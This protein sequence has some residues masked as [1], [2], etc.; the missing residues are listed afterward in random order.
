MMSAPQSRTVASHG[1]CAN[2]GQLGNRSQYWWHNDKIWI[3]YKGLFCGKTCLLEFHRGSMKSKH[4]ISPTAARGI[5]YNIALNAL[6]AAYHGEGDKTTKKAIAKLHN[7]LLD[8]SG[9]DG[10]AL[11]Y[12]IN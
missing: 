6:N 4:K 3:P 1:D 12:A 7:R 10:L 5:A 8:A 2:C 11:T 9:M